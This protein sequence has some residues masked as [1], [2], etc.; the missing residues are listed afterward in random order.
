VKNA[1]R[2][3]APEAPLDL[4]VT[5]DG[6]PSKTQR[7]LAMTE[8][9][10]LGEEMLRLTPEQ[11]ARLD[12]PET[13]RDALHAAARI[14]AHEGRR[15]QLQYIGRL[16]RQVDPEPI[17]R[18]LEDASGGSR[19][20]VSLMHRCERLRDQLLDDDAALTAFLAG[21][22]GVDAQPLR[23]L[24]RAARRERAQGT[25]PRQAR[26]LYR[27]LHATLLKTAEVS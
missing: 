3:G 22:P 6:R 18:A 14:H 26:E 27:F 19:A 9:Q 21:H 16:M 7:K 5:S 25:A 1:P 15:R 11:L 12:L 8:L 24:I 20:A 23:T 17:R 13:L 4:E 10:R 2:L